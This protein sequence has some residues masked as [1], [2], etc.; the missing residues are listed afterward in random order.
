MHL[1]S[2]YKCN[3]EVIHT[4]LTTCADLCKGVLVTYPL[5]NACQ[6]P[7]GISSD[8]QTSWQPAQK[9]VRLYWFQI[10]PL[11]HLL[12]FPTCTEFPTYMKWSFFLNKHK[13]PCWHRASNTQVPFLGGGVWRACVSVRCA[14]LLQG[15]HHEM[16]CGWQSTPS[17]TGHGSV[18]WG[19]VWEPSR[20]RCTPSPAR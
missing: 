5:P 19:T 18:E 1:Y 13:F 16:P 20:M 7:R 10:Q 3:T 14:H 11:V 2:L 12:S 9:A 8:P 15:S 6:H 4:L 17:S